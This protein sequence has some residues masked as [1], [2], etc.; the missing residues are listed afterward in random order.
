MSIDQLDKIDI[1]STSEAGDVV[2]HISDHLMWDREREH[3]QLLQDKIN[4][5]LQFIEDGQIF[6]EYPTATKTNISIEV[7]FKYDPP[8][9]ILIYLNCFKEMV[10]DFGVPLTWQ[11]YK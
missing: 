1:I 6:E 7:V 8:K 3:I 4:A 10:M 9:S 11:I 2:L 5:Y